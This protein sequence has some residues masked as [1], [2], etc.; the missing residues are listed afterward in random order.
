MAELEFKYLNEIDISDSLTDS[1]HVIVE[2]G[3][4]IRR[5]PMNQLVTGGGAS[6]WDD[7]G[8]NYLTLT[9]DGSTEGREVFTNDIFNYY[10]ISDTYIPAD[11][12]VGG[13]IKVSGADTLGIPSEIQI[14]EEL[15]L[16]A[17]D[18]FSAVG[19]TFPLIYSFTPE[20]VASEEELSSLSGG[21]YVLLAKA[22]VLTELFPEAAE[23]GIVFTEDLFAS[24]LKVADG[25]NLIPEKFLPEIDALPEVTTE[26]NGN[27]LTVVDGTWSAGE[28][29][30]PEQVNPDWNQN[31]STQPDYVK[32]RTHWVEGSGATIEWDGN[33]DGRD[34]VALPISDTLNMTFYKVSDAIPSASDI[35]GGTAEYVSNGVTSS[36]VLEESY[37][38]QNDGCVVAGETV[39]VVQ[40]T[41]ASFMGN[42]FAAPSTGV[43][44]YLGEGMYGSKLTY[45]ST[46]YHP[47]DEAFIPDTI[48]RKTDVTWENLPDKPFYDEQTVIEWD[49]NTE[50]LEPLNGLYYKVSDLTPSY[51]E[52]VG[53]TMKTTALESDGQ[54]VD[55]SV[56]EDFREVQEVMSGVF[57][58]GSLAYVINM[59]GEDRETSSLP[60]NGTYF[61][62]V[63]VD[64][65]TTYVKS[66]TYGFTKTIDPK[67]L[68]SAP[69]T[70]VNGITGDVVIEASGGLPEVTTENN[71]A[72]L[73]VVDGAWAIVNL[74]DV[75]VEGA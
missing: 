74:T 7:L 5:A 63:F 34:S 38:G 32:N 51:E 11:Q 6:S 71:G 42:S 15:I 24:K 60:A 39:L 8:Y 12:F 50:G 37:V 17:E 65:T 48:A 10:K 20:F 16:E 40:N 62:G 13:V 47:L 25:V 3:G 75:S 46:T 26:N 64:G 54:W 66:L 58:I 36:Y 53:C 2:D 67:F 41:E 45:G 22:E 44:F 61:Y 29:E 23:N 43:Y 33:T 70:S 57:Q 18:G 28:I 72:F 1:A 19:F 59:S 31:D 9:W 73:R 27:V 14:N 21:T 35:V 52:L 69:V 55:E 30:I 49:G 4:N 68:P 56:G